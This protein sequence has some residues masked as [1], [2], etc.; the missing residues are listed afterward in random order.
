MRRSTKC[1]PL[2][3]AAAAC[4]TLWPAGYNYAIDNAAATPSPTPDCKIVLGSAVPHDA[5]I[6]QSDLGNPTAIQ[7]DFDTLSWNTF[8]ALNWPAD[9]NNNGQPDPDPS[10][11]IGLQDYGPVVWETYKPTYNVFIADGQGNPVA[12]AAWNAQPSPPPGCDQNSAY[13]AKLG[14][15]VRVLKNI[16]KDGLNEFLEAFVLAPLI[17]QKG[18]FVRYEV[19]V[20]QQE[21]NNIVSPVD[22]SGK[23]LPPLYDSRNQT[24]VNFPVGQPT[25]LKGQSKSRPRGKSSARPTIPPGT[26]PSGFKSPGRTELSLCPTNVRS[27]SSS[28]W[29]P[30]TSLTKRLT[31]RSGLG[32]RLSRWTIIGRRRTL[33][34]GAKPLSIIPIACRPNARSTSLRHRPQPG[35]TATQVF[36][37]RDRPRRSCQAT[38]PQCRV[39]A[40]V[41]LSSSCA[42]SILIAFGST[43]SSSA[44]SGR[45]IRT[46][47]ANRARSTKHPRFSNRG[48][49]NY[50][51]IWL[52]VPSRP[53]SWDRR[54]SRTR[55]AAW[56]AT[57]ARPGSRRD[58][59][60]TSATRSRKR[61]PFPAPR[62]RG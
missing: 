61:I 48:P 12:P 6:P 35:G 8:I 57:T 27:R 20:N 44:P 37:T 23:P 2:V 9:P 46:S 58:N 55:R 1:I 15:P 3:A 18:A 41:R 31:R 52:T 51:S 4:A 33:P 43:I 54:K 7:V 25:D 34:K 21:F 22:S 42:A 39:G 16:S 19:L 10:K 32:R 47:R 40:T 5:T 26:I 14:K 24:D 17:D 13:A 53:T 49:I 11:K 29:S 30:C 36:S 45:K 28:G 62:A 59:L 56:P 38:R 50:R 60:S